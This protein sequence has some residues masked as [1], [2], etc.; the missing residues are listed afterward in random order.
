M[1]L[2]SVQIQA[3]IGVFS[4]SE[5]ESQEAKFFVNFYAQN[6]ILVVTFLGDLAEDCIEVAHNFLLGNVVRYMLNH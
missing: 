6:R 1:V 4:L 3:Y 2:G 5:L